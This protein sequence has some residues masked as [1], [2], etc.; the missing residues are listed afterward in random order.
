MMRKLLITLIVSL[1][2]KLCA[3]VE[4]YSHEVERSWT[5]KDGNSLQ[6]KLIAMNIQTGSVQIKSTHPRYKVFW[7]SVDKLSSQD[8][9]YISSKKIDIQSKSRPSNLYNDDFYDSTSNENWRFYDM[10]FCDVKLE[11]DYSEL[12]TVPSH[13]KYDHKTG[14]LKSCI[15]YL[16]NNPSYD[17]GISRMIREFNFRPRNGKLQTTGKN[18]TDG[19]LANIEVLH[20]LGL[21]PADFRKLRWFFS[22]EDFA[23]Y[24][25]K[26]Y[27][28][29]GVL[30]KVS[31]KF[32]ETE[33]FNER[34]ARGVP[35]ILY[36]KDRG[37]LRSRWS[38][39][40]TSFGGVVKLKQPYS[41]IIY[42]KTK[43]DQR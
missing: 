29:L 42:L 28:F 25:E 23:F 34:H 11:V 16:W 26:I 43:Q 20:Y 38:N 9:Y 2:S 27:K 19:I 15:L 8:K 3:N 1:T 24:P 39:F 40:Y 4:T 6:G 5:N 32:N 35:I 18:F 12:S 41:K 31:K 21:Q 37:E 22:A 30:D 36:W 10:R 7:Y 33:L 17:K 14:D 13:F